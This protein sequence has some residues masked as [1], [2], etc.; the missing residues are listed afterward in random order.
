MAP[1]ES[2]KRLA[3]AIIDFLGS[4]LKDGTLTADDAESI[5]IAQ[6]C[7][8]DTFKV[9]PTDEAAVKE[10]VGGQ[11]LASIY[12]VYEKLRS[13]STPQASAAGAQESQEQKAKAGAPTPESDKLKS[14]GNAL[15]AKKDYAAA[16]E[17]YSKALEIAPANPIYLSNRAA[18]YSASGQHEKAADDAEVAVAVDPKYSKAW[19]RLGLARFDMGDY[20]AAKEAY[21]KGIE[22]EGTG[23]S[24]AMKRGLETCN[25]KIEEASRAT[26]PPSE[27]LDTAP[28]ASRS[29]GGM[30][31]LSSLAGMFG[32][33]AGGAGGAGGMPD[34]GS[35]MN[36][37]MFASM[38]QN[39]MSNPDML[40]NLMS[41]PRLRQMAESFGQGG[42][43][44]DMSSLMSDPNIAEM[45]R[46]MM[47]GGGAGRGQ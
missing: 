2:K 23:G 19:S 7:I 6:S 16:I 21:E 26:E 18:A 45:A 14:E 8:A 10:A 37:P 1:T 27:E 42:G 43:M 24:D 39:L 25:K 28:G 38:A 35:M 30:P 9:D 31:D 32:G 5:E 3:L 47:G 40:G 41:N 4:S 33:G 36:N 20:H 13:K 46:N 44:P 11:S 12:S 29:A 17:S 15:M 34:L 22:A